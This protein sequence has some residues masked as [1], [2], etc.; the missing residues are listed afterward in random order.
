MSATAPTSFSNQLLDGLAHNDQH[1]FLAQC[2]T[3][4]LAFGSV[5][6]DRD[7]PFQYLYFPTSSFISLI[8]TLGGNHP[9]ELGLIG[10]E[11]MLGATLALGVNDAPSRAVVQGPGSALRISA[12]DLR[13]ALLD[14]P[15][16]QRALKHYLYVLIAQLT[17]NAACAH[18]HEIKPRLARWL[19]MTQDRAHSN[20]F[21]LTHEFL[22]DMLGVRRSGVTIAAGAL[23]V[24]QL[25][26]YSRGNITILDR[27][28]LELA[29]CE[30]YEV[31]LK[32]H[33]RLFPLRAPVLLPEPV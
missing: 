13:Q 21:H 22:A 4:E 2:E 32:D 6:C 25:I 28:G 1:R 7:Q 33:A 10:N 18:F 26:H 24:R 29:A 20:H 17:Q 12:A 11:G 16:L 19:L 23:Q 15:L 5:L 8:T 31:Q 9:L 27:P 30:C 3:V 14:I